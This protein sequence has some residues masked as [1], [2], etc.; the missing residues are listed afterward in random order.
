MVNKSLWLGEGWH[1]SLYAFKKESENEKGGKVPRSL[2]NPQEECYFF[3]IC[4]SWLAG[5]SF[6]INILATN[7]ERR[8]FLT[9][10]LVVR[11][12]ATRTIWKPVR[13]MT[14]IKNNP[15]THMTAI[16]CPRVK[17]TGVSEGKMKLWRTRIGKGEKILEIGSMFI[18]FN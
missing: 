17:E 8:L 12:R 6:Q 10:S 14:G 7:T 16:L 1:L 2:Q 4:P 3:F 11:P 13:P 5:F 9:C 15:A 18:I